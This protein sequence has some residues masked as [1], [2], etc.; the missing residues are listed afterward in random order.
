MADTSSNATGLV[1]G[2]GDYVYDVIRPFGKTPR[3]FATGYISHVA[4]DAKDRVYFYQRENPPILVF[5]SEGN[6]LDSWGEGRLVDAHGIYSG[7]DGH[8][9]LCNRD[10]HEVLKLTPEGK[11]VLTRASRAAVAAGAV[12]PSRGRRGRPER[13]HLRRRRLWQLRRAPVQCR[14]QASALVGRGRLR[15]RSVHDAAWRLGRRERSDLRRRP[16]EQS[17]ADLQ[18][19]GRLLRRMGRS[20][21]SD[22]HLWRRERHAL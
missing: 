20:L 13:R 22:G 11:I 12:Q 21:P 2:M 4:V 3:G 8:I 7:A 16:R 6:F 19:R 1:V 17:R 14:R 9:Y 10:E 5:D 15:T 18:P